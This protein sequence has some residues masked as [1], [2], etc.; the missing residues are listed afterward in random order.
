MKTLS[1]EPGFTYNSIIHNKVFRRRQVK[2]L[3]GLKTNQSQKLKK[4]KT[5][6][7]TNRTSSMPISD[8]DTG[9]SPRDLS[10]STGSKVDLSLH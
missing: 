4:H 9:I 7:K 3:P 10:Y 6:S 8:E 5:K 1:D 2:G